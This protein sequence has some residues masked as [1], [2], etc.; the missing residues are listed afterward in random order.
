MSSRLFQTV[1]EDQGLCYSI[2]S[3][4]SNYY[5]EGIFSVYTAL[6][7]DTEEKAIKLIKDVI[8]DFTENGITEEELRCVCEQ[9][10][11]NILMGL[12]S[13]S[14]RMH[15]LGRGELFSGRVQDVDEI[16]AAYD[17]ITTEDIKRLAEKHLDFKNVSF[18]AVGKTGTAD[19]YKALLGADKI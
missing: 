7:R 15:R 16:C 8:V 13:T 18:S 6:S 1:R 2:Y 5:K 4:C 9:A 3:Y 19:Y 10:K 17:K 14:T 12:E 11:S